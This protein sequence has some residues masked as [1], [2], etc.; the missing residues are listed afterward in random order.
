MAYIAHIV[1]GVWCSDVGICEARVCTVF[2]S[3]RS[4]IVFNPSA[5]SITDN[6]QSAKDIVSY[7]KSHL[8]V[9]DLGTEIRYSVY[10]MG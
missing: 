3:S 4:G 10:Q 5:V 9:E 2:M 8:Y 1:T 6:S 7:F